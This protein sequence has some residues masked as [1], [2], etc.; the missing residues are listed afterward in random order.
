MEQI[1]EDLVTAS[2]LESEVPDVHF[3]DFLAARTKHM[4]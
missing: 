1:P 3:T 4:A 2:H